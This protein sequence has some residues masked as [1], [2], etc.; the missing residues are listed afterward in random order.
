MLLTKNSENQAHASLLGENKA[1]LYKVCMKNIAFFAS[2]V[3]SFATSVFAD[4]STFKIVEEESNVEFS[5]PYTFGTHHGISK[6]VVGTVRMD[7]KS[8]Q[9]TSVNVQVPVST[10]K[11]GNE[12][13]EC[14]LREALG[15]DYSKSQFPG[16]HACDK[17]HTLPKE[18]PNSI[19]YPD[20]AFSI[21]NPSP[22]I[23]GKNQ[24]NGTWSIH[25]VSKS[26]LTSINITQPKKDEAKYIIDGVE[27]FPLDDFGIKVKPFFVVKVK[28]QAVAT[29]HIVIVK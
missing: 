29:F 2:L 26:R 24:I 7:P 10:F 16:K 14:H 17:K 18:G 27:I 4:S 6:H 28:E 13:M 1:P 5:L 12:E 15:L 25:G 22:F 19:V 9:L 21:Q 23:L 3:F 11:T 8:L 20:I